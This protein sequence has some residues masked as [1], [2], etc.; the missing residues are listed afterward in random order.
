M[1]DISNTKS[2]K[3]GNKKQVKK[4][5][6]LPA[7]MGPPKDNHIC[8]NCDTT[9][10]D[11]QHGLQCDCCNGW[12]HSGCEKV[13]AV[14]YEFLSK[15]AEE[16]AI[17]WFCNGCETSY[18]K[19]IT[20]V[21]RIDNVQKKLDD[22][23][24]AIKKVLDSKVQDIDSIVANQQ[25]TEDKMDIFMA[26]MTKESDKMESVKV[27]QK[28][29][30]DKV[31][32]LITWKDKI[33]M[34]PHDKISEETQKRVEEKMEEIIDTVKNQSKMD[35]HYVHSCVEDAVRIKMNMDQQE[36]EEIKKRRHNVI[37]HG[38]AESTEDSAEGRWSH[39]ESQVL[40]LLHEIQCDDVSIDKIIRLGRRPEDQSAKPRPLMLVA[41]SEDQKDKILRSAK[42]LRGRRDKGLQPIFLHQDLTPNQRA[43]RKILVQELNDRKSQG[44]KNL[45]IINGK[46]TQRR[47]HPSIARVM[48]GD[49][50]TST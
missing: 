30:E 29:L 44:E 22:K 39:D 36:E 23:V 34:E 46:I 9:V 48:Q 21:V 35:G 24:E 10:T 7:S 19:I 5:D 37:L 15:H 49:Q 38:L 45:I 32:T 47:A 18:R 27:N 2:T 31:D 3:T 16:K 11:S 25:R 4:D 43:A 1:A 26:S 28:R 17:F 13:S 20:T 50:G 41:A 14:T 40:E 8:P 33:S 12:F 6:A 42:N